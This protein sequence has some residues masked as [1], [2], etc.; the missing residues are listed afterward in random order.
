M[1]AN[2]TPIYKEAEERYRRATD[3]NERL[4]ALKE[5]LAVIP[6]HKGTDKLQ[7][8]IKAKIAKLKKSRSAKK[9]GTRQKA[10]D[11][12]P[13][14][15]AA[16]IPLVGAPNCGKSQFLATLTNARPDIADYPY[17]TRIPTTA[18]MEWENIKFQLIDL[19][20]VALASYE[21]W[22]KSL[23]F[24]ADVIFLFADLSSDDLIDDVQTILNMLDY[25]QINLVNPDFEREE[26][27]LTLD[28]VWKKTFLLANKYDCDE[29]DIRLGFL[30]EAFGDRFPIYKINALTGEGSDELKERLFDS[31]GLIR[32]YTKTPGRDAY[33]TDPVL[34][35]QPATV[36]DAAYHIHKDF[37][38]KLTY[39][40]IW[41]E[42]KFDGQRVQKDFQIADGDILEFHL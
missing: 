38:H 6:K 30:T 27:Q 41:G 31:L 12:I 28:K 22:M 21:G 8:E 40:R 1:P 3:D 23:L 14:E 32:I 37:A 4:A 34:L 39:A 7:G 10:P 2:L 18:M 5:M 24:R 25:Q 9:G 26:D 13:K 42:G 19:P 11:N 33:M 29:E 20:P 16:Q 35:M 15:G 36:A 17:T